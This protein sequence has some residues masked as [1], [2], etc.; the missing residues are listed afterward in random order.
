M[1]TSIPASLILTLALSTLGSAVAAR[2]EADPSPSPVAVPTATDAADGT[3]EPG[4]SADEA[5]VAPDTS[6]DDASLAFSDPAWSRI[7]TPRGPAARE[8]H[9][10]T[11]GGGGHYAYLFGGRD[12]G[13]E[14]GDL[15]RY[16]LQQDT[17]ERLSPRGTRP[18]PRFGHS[19]VWVDG[20][21]VVIFAGQRGPDFFRDL[22]AY[23]PGVD[24]WTRLPAR[25]QAPR[26]RYGSC[27]V[28]GADGR[29][30]VSHG[31]TSA[32][33]FDDTRAYN[34][35][36]QRW[37]SIAPD[38]GRPGERC[39]HDCFTAADGSLVLY[40]GQDDGAFALG[41]LWVMGRERTWDRLDD[42][43]PEPRRLYAVAEA[44][45][46]AYLFGGAGE[47]N[48][49]FDD[50]WRVDRESLA[51]ERVPVVGAGPSPRSAGTLISDTERGRLLLFGG[52]AR[53]ARADVWEL[54]DRS[55]T[56]EEATTPQVG[57]EPTPQAGAEPAPQ[58]SSTAI[59]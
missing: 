53:S 57:D 42:P 27:M 26:P 39:L 29:L 21:G 52:Q 34:L 47:D 14:F 16:D 17:W 4:R 35:A 2:D 18:Q 12:G 37:A 55:T 48:D 30:W 54:V 11:V 51:F 44:G 7:R 3:A 5:A 6:A 46:V 38:A 9:T 50:L 43:R 15:W 23:D 58:A 10:W 25:G 28:L 19:A 8:D 22:W 49:A 1:R 56:G 20:L 31:F 40:G 36:R 32:G 13:R 41:D 33:R 59:P 45:G 24:R